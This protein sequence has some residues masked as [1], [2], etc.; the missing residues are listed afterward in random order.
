MLSFLN[1][2]IYKYSQLISY[3]NLAQW[4]NKKENINPEVFDIYDDY[5]HNN[6]T[7]RYDKTGAELA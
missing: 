3:Q 6:S 2:L 4:R 7:P 1:L 5:V